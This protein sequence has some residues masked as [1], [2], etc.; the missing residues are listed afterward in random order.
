MLKKHGFELT[1]NFPQKVSRRECCSSGRLHSADIPVEIPRAAKVEFEVHK[2][3][4][5]QV[6]FEY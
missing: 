3:A 1:L 6:F 4:P 5:G 2:V